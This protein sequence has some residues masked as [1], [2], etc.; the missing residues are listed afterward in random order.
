MGFG[1]IQR[2]G[3][4]LSV[5]HADTLTTRSKESFPD[6]LR[7]LHESLNRVIEETRPDVLAMEKQIYCQNIKTALVLGQTGGMAALSAG[8]A[9]IAFLEFTPLEIKKA[10]TGNGRAQKDQVLRMVQTLL[11]LEEAPSTEHIADALACALCY[12]FSEKK[13][14]LYQSGR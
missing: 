2:S 13:F 10:V 6:R 11:N 5:L 12:I 3:D 8:V 1:V 7:Y 14:Q 9:G 4:V